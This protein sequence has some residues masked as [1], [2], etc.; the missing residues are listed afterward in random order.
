MHDPKLYKP[1]WERSKRSLQRAIVLAVP[2]L[3]VSFPLTRLWVTFILSRSPFSP[4]DIHNAA[5][6]G[7]SPVTY[8]TFTLTL[9]Q[10]SMF[11]EWMLARELRKSRNEV[12]ERT[13]ESRGKRAFRPSVLVHR[14]RGADSCVLVQPTTGGNPIPKSGPFRP[15]PERVALPRS[16][17]STGGCRVLSFGCYCSKVRSCAV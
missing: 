6:L 3:L 17:R 8:T 12:Y 2:F 16:I 1:I 14:E 10:V 4:K 7:V 9:G 13:V 5:Y 15:S 11:V